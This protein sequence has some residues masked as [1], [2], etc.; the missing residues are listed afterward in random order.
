MNNNNQAR[1]SHPATSVTQSACRLLLRVLGWHIAPFPDVNKAVVVGGPHTSNWDGLLGLVGGAA[2]GLQ[3]NI[4]IKANLFFWPLGPLMRRFGA[5]PIN[6]QQNSGVVEQAVAQIKQRDRM[7]MVVTPE[8]TRSNAPKWKT[9]FYHI[10]LQA[11]VPIVVATADYGKK[12][13]TYPAVVMPSGDI[14]ADFE[15]FYSLFANVTPKHPSKLSAPVKEKY[16]TRRN[17]V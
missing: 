8:G 15:S 1:Y 16:L 9:G 11:E 14:D 2:L 7:I 4:M 6:R 3:V 17:S 12:E 5:I 13:I 10:A